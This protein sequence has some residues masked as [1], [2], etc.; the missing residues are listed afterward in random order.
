MGGEEERIVML[1]IFPIGGIGG[2]TKNMFVYE[3]GND[4]LVVDC[5]I[6]FPDESMPGVE[7][8]IP[9]VTYL[10]QR[11]AA[12]ATLHGVVLTHG[13][14]D[15]IAALPYVVEELDLYNIPIHGSPLT[16]EFAMA[17][18]ADKGVTKEVQHFDSGKLQ[19]GP[20]TVETIRITHSV[21]D[22][23]HLVITTA[24]GTF[25]HGSDFKLDLNPVDGRPSDLQAIAEVGRRGVT[26]ALLD[27]LR[28][29]RQVPT[30]S[31][32]VL[33]GSLRREFHDVRGT[34]YVTL[35]SSN[36]HR[37]QQVINIAHE[38][39]RKVTF[40]GRSVEQNVN[41]ATEMGL[42]QIPTGARVGK[43]NLEA[44][45]PENLCVIIAG[46]QGQPGSSMVRAVSGDHPIV[47]IQKGDKVIIASEP[48][49]GSEKNVY[50]L[51]NEIAVNGVECV[52]SDIEDDLHVS[53]HASAYEQMMMLHL[54]QP[55][56]V[57][58]IGGEERHRVQFQL[59]IEKH[60]L[61][62]KAVVM[63]MEGKEVLFENGKF[64]YGEMHEL[65][66]R[67]VSLGGIGDVVADILT[68]RTRLG[69]TGVLV[70]SLSG[71]KV[72]IASRGFQWPSA[73]QQHSIEQMIYQR[74][75]QIADSS[76][77]QKDRQLEADLRKLLRKELQNS[78][79]ELI[80]I[81]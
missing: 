30:A 72:S 15:H 65:R 2:V 68:Q 35:M 63:P 44:V 74:A 69:Q 52:Y 1:K 7:F 54:L 4:L 20:F 19:L 33:A 17:R 71:E 37:V 34:V 66:D 18:M 48:I 73:D 32:S 27:C 76:D 10:K 28:V 8:L 16:A 46:S 9:D 29:E 77:P 64:R 13:H 22:T 24:E 6:G 78:T 47:Q 60:G 50:K 26:C 3:S 79:P 14:D 42:V 41:I 49:P 81:R 56:S 80:V 23:R 59:M 39:G 55:E 31:E 70:V 43:R 21:P 12:G 67:T 57:F 62:P 53:G 61:D 51:I 40:V 58:P 11:L 45:R 5:G 38:F 75:D 36:L 25:Y